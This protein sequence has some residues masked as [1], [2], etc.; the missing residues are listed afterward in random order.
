MATALDAPQ[1]GTQAE[2]LP[3]MALDA[4]RIGTRSPRPLQGVFRK[5]RGKFVVNWTSC[6]TFFR[7][8]LPFMM[9][10]SVLRE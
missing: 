10:W 9:A 7:P 8:I 1:I 4:L 6:A 2:Q 5:Q 3:A